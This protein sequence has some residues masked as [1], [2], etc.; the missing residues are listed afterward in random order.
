MAD[1]QIFNVAGNG[2][3]VHYPVGQQLNINGKHCI[4]MEAENG[5]TSETCKKCA[6]TPNTRPVSCKSLAC[7]MYERKD[8]KEVYF[9]QI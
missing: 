6:V 1:G 2:I 7:G 8:G 4:V 5:A 3:L 9:K